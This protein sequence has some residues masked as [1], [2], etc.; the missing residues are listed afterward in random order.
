MSELRAAQSDRKPPRGT[1]RR[2]ATTRWMSLCSLCLTGDITDSGCH[3][4]FCLS[5]S[6]MFSHS[7]NLPRRHLA[8]SQRPLTRPHKTLASS[9]IGQSD[10]PTVQMY[11]VPVNSDRLGH[12]ANCC[13]KSINIWCRNFSLQIL[14]CDQKSSSC[15]SQWIPLWHIGNTLRPPMGPRNPASASEHIILSLWHHHLFISGC[16]L[17]LSAS[18]P[19][20]KTPRRLLI[21]HSCSQLPVERKEERAL[22][23]TRSDSLSSQAKSVPSRSFVRKSARSTQHCTVH[24]PRTPLWKR[25]A[26]GF[27][28]LVEREENRF[29]SH[30]PRGRWRG[31]DINLLLQTYLPK[32]QELYSRS[33]V[34]VCRK[35]TEF[36][37]HQ[38]FYYCQAHWLWTLVYGWR[39]ERRHWPK[40]RPKTQCSTLETHIVVGWWSLFKADG[41]DFGLWIL[42]FL[43]PPFPSHNP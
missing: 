6:S 39:D 16:F 22:Q 43:P 38:C 37:H 30:T 21:R 3:F 24:K 32:L 29:D 9:T 10:R 18:F 20:R 14:K 25:F 23:F 5:D 8:L 41:V 15:K 36:S 27:R 28:A 33:Q 42:N 26:V 13:S 17:H 7:L 35:V 31:L 4:T 19:E 34:S 2:L 12:P 1:R 40:S 11:H